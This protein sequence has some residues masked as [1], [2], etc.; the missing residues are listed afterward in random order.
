MELSLLTWKLISAPRFI[1]FQHQPSKYYH[2]Y[3]RPSHMV[4]PSGTSALN[5]WKTFILIKDFCPLDRNRGREEML[6]IPAEH[7]DLKMFQSILSSGLCYRSFEVDVK[8]LNEL[9][10]V[11]LMSLKANIAKALNSNPGPSSKV[12]TMLVCEM[13]YT[14]VLGP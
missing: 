7:T 2:L 11:K 8:E 14:F 4:C 3:L 10:F 6:R 5:L 1:I 9:T 12:K 13:K